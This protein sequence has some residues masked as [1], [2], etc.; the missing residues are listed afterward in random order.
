MRRD[1]LRPPS[2][3]CLLVVDTPCVNASV[4]VRVTLSRIRTEE[5]FC[6]IA[7]AVL[8]FSTSKSLDA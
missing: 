2:G 4:R 1:A 6:S 3:R 8:L 5:L 7:R